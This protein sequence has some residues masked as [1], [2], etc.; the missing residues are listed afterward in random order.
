MAN[1][2]PTI[3]V[4]LGG[5]GS[6]I[7]NNIYGNLPPEK[8]ENVAIHAFDTDINSI[9]NLEHLGDHVTQTSTKRSIEEY[10]HLHP[11]LK[12]WFP[13][14]PYLLTKN[15]TQGAGQ[16][17]SVSRLAFRCAMDE[18]KL[19]GLEESIDRIFSVT[20]SEEIHGIRVIIICSLVGGTGSGIFLQVA[21]Y[22]REL[23][24]KKYSHSSVLIRGAFL[25]PDIFVRTKTVDR[26]EYETIWANGY[27]AIK[28][29]N[30]ITLSAAGQ[31]KNDGDVTINLEY[32][33]NQV[34]LQGRAT[35]AIT[36]RQLPL[37]FCFL[38]DYENT[39]GQNLPS[40]T[41]YIGQIS[42]T[43][44]LQLFS[45][46]SAKQ[47]SKEDNQILQYV[48][49]KG[50]AYFSGAGAATLQY[51]FEDVLEYLSLRWATNGLDESWLF[52][53]KRY[54]A[55]RQSYEKDLRKGIN[56]EKPL[57][58]QR[59][60]W[61]LENLVKEDNPNPFFR[62][63]HRQTRMI[64]KDG[65]LGP[66]KAKQF[67][68]AVNKRVEKIL[69]TDEELGSYQRSCH[70]DDEQLNDKYYAKTEIETMEAN[71]RRYH[72][73]IKKRVRDYQTSIAHQIIDQDSDSP[74]GAEGQDY[75][76][77]TWFLLKGTPLHPVAVR[78][79]LYEMKL[80][81]QKEIGILTEQC[82]EYEKGF[83]DYETAFNIRNSGDSEDAPS[84]VDL[85]LEQGILG[86][87]FRSEFKQFIKEYKT[88]ATRQVRHLT[89]YKHRLLTLLVYQ[90][91]SQA[92]NTMIQDW[93]R[94]F[95]NLKDTRDSL[96]SEINLISV[97]YEENNDPTFEYVLA[98]KEMLETMW[99]SLV[100]SLDQ[101]ILPDE[102]SKQIYLSHYRQYCLR[103]ERTYSN[104]LKEIAV[105]EMYRDQV[106]AYC[107]RELQNKYHERIDLS[108]TQALR[109]EA[110]LK[111]IDSREHTTK[112]IQALYNLSSP[113]I[114]LV[115]DRR[116]LYNYG[117]NDQ[118]V[119][120]LGGTVLHE[121]FE[122]KEVADKAFPKNEV[123]IYKAHYGLEVQNFSKFS[124]GDSKYLPGVYY[125]AYRRKID[126]LLKNEDATITPHLDKHWHLS[127]FMPDLNEDQVQLETEKNARA[128][129][130]GI[131]Y[132]WIELVP[133]HGRNVYMFTGKNGPVMIT[134][135]GERVTEETY[136][137]H[138]ALAYNPLINKEILELFEARLKDERR[139]FRDTNEHS[140]VVGTLDTSG[141]GKKDLVNILDIIF[142]YED[143]GLGDSSLPQKG[144]ILFEQLLTEI[145][146]YFKEVYGEHR[147]FEWRKATKD[148]IMK[149]WNESTYFNGR[150]DTSPSYKMA[151][152][153]IE[154][155]VNG[156][157][158]NY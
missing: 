139:K 113:F 126:S 136:L 17:R 28:E 61:N 98:T 94:F 95:D 141:L 152:K 82:E 36:K 41:E 25:L 114:P 117:I 81:L 132:G 92:I 78:Y 7:V 88:K 107:R 91:V 153:A 73:Q 135:G 71:I 21:M 15:M 133:E 26:T 69:E 108:I 20:S 128:L 120:E 155:K 110:E 68:N 22:L 72:D 44:Y 3:L 109:T 31:L 125:E 97:K 76:L 4:G 53:D 137:L 49:S 5:I 16:I 158:N 32:R 74:G 59:Y 8:R 23:L 116:E 83:K 10:L 124:S 65:D 19:S 66:S 130:L 154:T 35:H 148:L 67:I 115:E 46:I 75:R 90:S 101:G 34:D 112:R 54:E 40:L 146:D 119:N 86:R 62:Q 29:L 18:G 43:I 144:K 121:I 147:D 142:A 64:G 102:I 127:T 129:L 105:E 52:L 50:K 131:I 80:L 1:G 99:Q 58:E 14:N 51:P 12:N 45:P 89:E 63:V 38:Y 143:E 140:F 60:I 13:E 149:L 70:L 87:I 122:G 123:V 39:N 24:E 96:L 106:L 150:K 103:N 104:Y 118:L 11:S 27:A 138:S 56:R 84:R 145:E 79:M 151:K 9:R 57:K 100:G 2:V 157:L 47:F 42:R 33:P 93:E 77:N 48:K 30:A 156:L 37:N 6:Q 111:G 55:E 134:K 85:A